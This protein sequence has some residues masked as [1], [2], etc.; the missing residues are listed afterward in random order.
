[1][2]PD[3][4]ILLV[5]EGNF[6]FA[7]SLLSTV[8]GTLTVTA[9]AY[10]TAETVAAKYPD[11]AEHLQTLADWDATVVFGVDATQL[12]AT[13]A[14]RGR[15]F[16]KI[17]FNFPHVGAGVKDQER[18]VALN[19]NL[20]RAFLASAVPLLAVRDTPSGSGDNIH[21][22]RDGIVF[23]TVKT[24]VPY[25]LWD[26]KRLG[27]EAGLLAVKS[28]NFCPDQFPGY[29]HRRTIGFEEGLSVTD[30]SEITKKAPR[31]F[32]FSM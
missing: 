18:N 19:Q 6:S 29:E 17:L 14:L 4:R 5:G 12:G 27:R 9:T 1:F 25:D 15:R 20:V 23:V 2:Q 3:D 26:V 28:F 11:A 21:D 13:Q 10:D 8:G 24:G 30:N 22:M 31:T 7:A 16:T 32:A